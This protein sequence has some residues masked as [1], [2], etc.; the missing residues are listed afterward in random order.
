MIRRDAGEQWLLISQV[1]H[2]RVAAD[3]AMAW[4][5][6][7]VARLPLA[8]WLVPAVRDHDEGW[9]T[10]ETAPTVTEDGVPRQFTEMS[11]D[12]ANEI[13]G[14][15]IEIS[16]S[17][18][19]SLAEALR[20][21]RSE[22]GEVTPDDA[23]VLDAV[24][25]HRGT[26]SVE[27]LTAE[28]VGEGDLGTEAVTASLAR[29]ERKGVIRQ[30]PAIVGGP[31]FEIMIPTTGN[32]PLGGIWVSKHFCALAEGAKERLA[33]DTGETA[34]IDAFLAEQASRQTAWTAAA[35]EFAGDEL[36]RVIDTGFRYVQF[37]DRISLWLCM[38]ERAEPWDAA[39]S[40]SLA[41]T[42]TPI[43]PREITVSPWPFRS[44]ALEVS[45]PAMQLPARAFSDDADLRDALADADRTTLRWV[46]TQ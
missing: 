35:H 8:E 18:F 21:L 24:L 22:G 5:N 16:A 7:D 20:R 10:W 29:F 43:S 46:L 11:V 9:R 32:S 33:D 41:L 4:G 3:L 37:F 40:S 25:R 34:K 44:G 19:G 27:R 36:D 17:G 6:D 12:V 13:W 15:S 26:C 1:D 2:A 42:F 38:A 28:V 30:L 45:T 23:A 14:R 31:A 39:L